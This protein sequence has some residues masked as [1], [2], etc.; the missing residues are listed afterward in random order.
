MINIPNNNESD[1][2]S[3]IKKPSCHIEDGLPKEFQ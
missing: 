2:E 3:D 1:S